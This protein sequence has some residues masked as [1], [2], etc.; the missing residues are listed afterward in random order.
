MPRLTEEEIE[1]LQE[2]IEMFDNTHSYDCELYQEVKYVLNEGEC[3]NPS[4]LLKECKWR[5][6]DTHCYDTEL[7][8]KLSERY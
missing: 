5:L 7:Y 2:C 3:S 1:L 4:Q 8:Y 6:D